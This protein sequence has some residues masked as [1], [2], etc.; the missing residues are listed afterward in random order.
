MEDQIT[1]KVREETLFAGIRKPV[2]S[3]KELLPRMEEV[4]RVCGERAVSPLTVI[5]R[6]DTP[7]EGFDAEV[8]FEVSE[9][10][11]VG[12]VRTH[13][14]RKLHFFS[15]THSGPMETLRET[16]LKIIDH[17]NKTGLSSELEDVEIYHTYDPDRPEEVVIESRLAYLAWPEIYKEQLVRVLGPELAGEIWAGGESVTPFTLVDERVTWVGESLER[18][19]KHTTPAQQFDV[20]SRVALVRPI[21]DVNKFKA[22]YEETGD[23][24]AVIAR[25]DEQLRQ[26]PTGGF[27]DPHWTDGKVLHLSKVARDRKAYDEAKT[28]DELRQAYC[29]CNLIRQAKAPKVDPIFCY[30][31]AG[32]ARQFWEPILGVEFETC[33]ITHS[34]LKGDP[35]CAW[36]YDL[37]DSFRK[38]NPH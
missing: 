32:W 2:K 30:R 15:L 34:I 24:D 26:T 20:L 11:D 27:I 21:E 28:H 18:L 33:T 37:P 6:F 1:P 23:I 38:G 4:T 16:K 10:V 9:P 36:E 25:Q 35:F 5:F 8:G 7:V 3:R 31:A 12:E 13:T 17:M 19:K 29:F 22:I 14:L